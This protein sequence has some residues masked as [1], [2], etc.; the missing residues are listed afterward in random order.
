M[1]AFR[2]IRFEVQGDFWGRYLSHSPHF[3]NLTELVGDLWDSILI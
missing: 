2:T 3:R 1:S